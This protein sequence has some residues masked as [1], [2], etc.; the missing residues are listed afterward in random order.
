MTQDDSSI[1][2]D[3]FLKTKYN[4]SSMPRGR[5]NL[6]HK[7]RTHKTYPKSEKISLPTELPDINPNFWDIVRLR[8]S[9]RE[10][11]SSLMTIKELSALL[12]ASQGVT[13][14]TGYFQFRSAPSAGALYPIETYLVV[15]NIESLHKGVFHY[16]VREHA[17]EQLRAI[18]ASEPLARACLDQDWM[19]F[20]NVVFIWTAMFERCT[21]KYSQRA[22]RYMSLDAGHIAHAVALSAV[23]LG[24]GSCQVAAF[25]DG[26]LNELLHIDGDQESALYV[27]AVGRVD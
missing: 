5:L 23:A 11:T 9:Q 15:N 8:R 13:K 19:M 10:F 20:A 12:W 6:L 26:E 24:L 14:N 27:T 17:L 7:P 25:Y 4:R 1:G 16:N 2:H 21:W 18:N 3:F 22:Y